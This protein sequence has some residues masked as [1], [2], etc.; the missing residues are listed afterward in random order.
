MENEH[1]EGRIVNIDIRDEM[2]TSYLD[3][4]MSVIVSRA[5]PDVRDGLKPVHRRILYSMSELGMT[6]DKPHRK[7][8][9][10][11]GDVLGKF[12]PHGDSAVY[13]AMVRLAQEFSTRYMLVDGHGN[14]GSVD[15]DSAAAMRYTEARMSKIALEMMRDIGKDTIDYRLNFDET[16]NEPKV[17][18]SRFPNL[19]VNGSSGIA[20]GMATSIPPHNLIEVVNGIVGM[21]DNSE[22]T[23]EELLGFI[24]GPDFPTG[25]NIMGIENIREAYRTGRGKVIVRAEAEIEENEK[26]R[27]SIIITELPYQ[28]NKAKQI[29]RIAELVR[30]KKL[31]GISDLRDESDRTGM[32]IVVEIKRDFN[33]NI[34]LNNLYKYTQ[35]QSTFS[36]ILLALVDEQP[37]VLTLKQIIRHYLDHQIEVIVRRTQFDLNRAEERAH[38]LEGLKIALD[39]IDAVIKLIRGSDTGAEAKEGLMNN[40]SLSDRQAQAILDMRLQRLTGLERGKIEEEYDALMIEVNRLKAI[41]ASKELV[42]N[43]IKDELI[44]IKEKYGDERRTEIKASE[45]EINIEDMIQ[46][47]CIA[48]TLTHFGYIKRLPEDTYKTQRRGGRGVA[49][50]TT[51]ED[52]FVEHLYITSTHDNLLFFTNQGRVYS[53]KGYEIPEARRQARGTAIINLLQLMP[54]EKITAVIPIRNFTED[55][56][57]ILVTKKGVTKRLRL[58]ELQNIRKSGLIAISLKDQDELMGV[59]KTQG[60]DKIIL[61]TSAG[62]SIVFEES[63]VRDMGR[64][65]M[66]VRAIRLN[67]DDYLV[68]MDL[69]EEDKDLLVISE[70]GYGKRTPLEEYRVQTRGGKGVKTYNIKDTTGPIINAKVVDVEDEVMMISFFGTIIRLS[71]SD[72]ST[73]GRATQGVRLMKMGKDDR[74]VSVAKT[75]VE[76]FEKICMLPKADAEIEDENEVIEE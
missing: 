46:E 10:I 45:E 8:A 71:V 17:L 67:K 9:R 57:L 68:G 5:L 76:E 75:I 48:V 14:F 16:L 66:G 74:V 20:V 44:E 59:R 42:Y 41:L 1:N 31:E 73:M 11:V 27:S 12:H 65:A 56:F 36:I 50:L 53:M 4:A 19:L 13:N 51:R 28:V 37:K 7:S 60:D 40:F 39:N 70:F 35:F 24:K 43:I 21:I 69:I 47:E 15:G 3:Y 32:R 54:G 22:I 63:D 2:K 72:I 34:V 6:P 64:T 55:N 49:G 29:E 30:D 61:V 52:D 26:G 33:A 38:I 18:P 62:M 23:T 25:G 58:N